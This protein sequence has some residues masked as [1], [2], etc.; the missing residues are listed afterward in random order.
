MGYFCAE[1]VQRTGDKLDRSVIFG[2][3][4]PI[5]MQKL[6][7]LHDVVLVLI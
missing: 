6:P 4:I 7:H 5:V 1:V 2:R 3:G